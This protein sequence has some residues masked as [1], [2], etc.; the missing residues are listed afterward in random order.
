MLCFKFF[1]EGVKFTKTVD[2]EFI[3]LILEKFNLF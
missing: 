2:E 1:Y 3:Y